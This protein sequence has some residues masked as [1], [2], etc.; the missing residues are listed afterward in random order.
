MKPL[1][2]DQKRE[3][4]GRFLIVDYDL[5]FRSVMVQ[6]FSLL[7]YI[8]DEAVNGEEALAL[9]EARTYQIV[10]L[11]LE[12][13]DVEGVD[14]LHHISKNYPDVII[15]L[16]AENPTVENA[17][18]AVKEASAFLLKPVAINEIVEVVTEVIQKQAAL[19]GYLLQNVF[20]IA[21]GRQHPDPY[22]ENFN[23]LAAPTSTRSMIIVSPVK[24]NCTTQLVQRIDDPHHQGVELTRGE[25]AV[26]S[27]LMINSDQPLSCQELAHTAWGYELEKL[28]AESVIRPYISRIRHKLS[29]DF[30]GIEL[31]KTVRKQGYLFPTVTNPTII[32]TRN[33]SN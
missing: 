24:L 1:L 4:E 18:A 26:L 15:I 21:N 30:Q 27:C 11:E 17:L 9:L 32:S 22:M 33:Y 6:V 20:T 12:L 31:I 25:T 16:I 13:R 2:S 5:T 14:L 23:S 3:G 29:R 10:I 19:I 7:G 8:V 28:D